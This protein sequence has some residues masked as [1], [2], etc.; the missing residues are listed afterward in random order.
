MASTTANI[1]PADAAAIAKLIG[2]FLDAG[3]ERFGEAGFITA[4]QA[5]GAEQAAR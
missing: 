4:I 5:Y 1:H 2:N 3:I